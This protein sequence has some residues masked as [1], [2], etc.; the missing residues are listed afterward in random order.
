MSDAFRIGHAQADTLDA[1]VD[2]CLSQLGDP[3]QASLGFVYAT[4]ALAGELGSVLD[5]LRSALSVEHWLGTVGHGV[6]ATGTEYYESPALV[7][8][9]A[10]LD[11]SGYRTIPLISNGTEA[12]LNSLTSWASGQPWGF[13]HGD[14][15]NPL[16]P[17]LL[18]Q[19][20]GLFGG[21]LLSG[22]L[23]S[24][25]SNPNRIPQII[26]EVTASGLSGVLFDRGVI[27]L[28]INHT[29]GCTPIGPR[30][31]ASEVERNVLVKL[32][33]RPAL[34]VLYEDVGEVL[35]RDIRRAA[36][37]I[38]VGLPLTG[39]EAGDYTVR[40]LIGVDTQRGLVGVGDY[41]ADGDEVM[42]C[43]RDG[44]TAR[45]DMYRMLGELREVTGGRAPRGG[46]YVSCVGRGRNQFGDESGEVAMIHE[47]LGDFPLAG[48][49]ANGEIYRN[50]LYGYT[51]V[52]TL[53]L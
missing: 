53:F 40:N 49:F 11:E 15:G 3:P 6:V 23:S 24:S 52:L 43:R 9:L 21:A 29:Q 44:N 30:H 2:G 18:E 22:G 4:E 26:D 31:R 38:F 48:F 16:V 33:E 37:Y 35:A 50:R 45:E 20:P 34:D 41:V 47:I 1:L 46:L 36:G 5:R 10:D 19:L 13:L 7:V 14:P 12:F 42:F 32:D 27:P 25:A 28:A 17:P 51:G 8:M 39:E